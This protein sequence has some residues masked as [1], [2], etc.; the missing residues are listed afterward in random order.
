M[1]AESSLHAALKDLYTSEP[2]STQ[3]TLVDGY[4]IDVVQDGLLIEIQTRNFTYLKPKLNDLL[5]RHT[6]RLVHPIA[7]EKWIVSLPAEGDQ[8]ISRRKS[9]RRGRVEH[10]FTEMVRLPDLLAHPNFSLEIVFIREEELR[11]NDG[12]GSWRRGGVS[13]AD[14]RLLS[15]V[16]R[17]LFQNPADLR[18]LLP[19]HLPQPFTNLELA[20]ELKIPA[21]LASR[22]SYCLRAANVI[23]TIGKQQRRLLYTLTP[24]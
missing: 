5:R 14:R 3:E 22:M 13:I 19:S 23:Q 21:R 20:K 4:W 10:L 8:P 11:R 18:G 15:V 17:R 12:H 9:P 24:E 7:Q 6:V 2:G 1:R 16:D